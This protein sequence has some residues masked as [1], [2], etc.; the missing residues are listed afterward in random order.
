MRQ[1]AVMRMAVIN[2]AYILAAVANDISGFCN[3]LLSMIGDNVEPSETPAVTI[4]IAVERF[5]SKYCETTPKEGTYISPPPS[6]I[7]IPWQINAC[8]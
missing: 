3:R 6:P 5:L 4:G 7:P 2:P 1:Q 8:E